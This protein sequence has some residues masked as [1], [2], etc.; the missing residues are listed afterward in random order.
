MSA[1][2]PS[3]LMGGIADG[4]PCRPCDWRFC[5]I[6][7]RIPLATGSSD[8]DPATKQPKKTQPT[9]SLLE[10]LLRT[11]VQSQTAAASETT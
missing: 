2:A 3:F 7:I 6:S 11:Q 5:R 10:I 4:K 1:S 8:P 9:F